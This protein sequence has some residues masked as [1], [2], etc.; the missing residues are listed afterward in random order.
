MFNFKKFKVSHLLLSISLFSTLTLGSTEAMDNE[1]NPT[2]QKAQITKYFAPFEVMPSQD[3]IAHC[4]PR[5]D[6][7]DRKEV[8]N[9]Y[10]RLLAESPLPINEGNPSL[11]QST[12]LERSRAGGCSFKEGG[13]SFPPNASIQG[14]YL[15][16]CGQAP[17][18]RVLDVGPGYGSDTIM[19]L[20]TQNTQVTAVDIYPEQLDILNDRVKEICEGKKIGRFNTYKHNF[21]VGAPPAKYREQFDIINAN[22]VFHFLNDDQTKKMLEN[23]H[24]MLKKYSL[25]FITVSTLTEK[26]KEYEQFIKNKKADLTAPGIIYYN[27]ERR[28]ITSGLNGTIIGFTEPQRKILSKNEAKLPTLGHRIEKLVERGSDQYHI[29]SQVRHFH[30]LSTLEN[31]LF[32]AFEIVDNTQ[33]SPDLEDHFLSVVARKK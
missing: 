24:F 14:P 3:Y 23:F 30:D 27:I 22:K 8:K 4:M 28:A 21:S 16:A 1:E 6:N 26:C 32:P 31:Y 19:A 20:L 15:F 10:R 12:L 13:F 7:Q 33:Y 29:V 17:L 2:L 5:L 11:S 25:V 9:V 18:K